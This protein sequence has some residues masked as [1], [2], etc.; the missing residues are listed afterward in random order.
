[1]K[2]RTGLERFGALAI[3]FTLCGFAGWLYETVLTSAVLGEFA[4][5]GVLHLPVL[6]IYGF[7]GLALTPLLKNK[8]VPAVFLW[9]T[10]LCTA[11]ELAASYFLEL[12]TPNRLWAYDSWP[13]N[14]DGRISLFSSLIFGALCVFLVKVLHP[15]ACRLTEK[16]GSR[17]LKA[18]SLLPAAMLADLAAILLFGK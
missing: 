13:L 4:Q 6:P 5:R 18:A 2:K 14:F 10:A 3:E 9:G 17:A 7:G 15:F 8:R 16:A 11:I 12:F 1:M